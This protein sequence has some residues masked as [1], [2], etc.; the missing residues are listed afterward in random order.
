MKTVTEPT[1]TA[2]IYIAGSMADVERQCAEYC[3][4]VGLCV[5]VEPVKFIYTGGRE[6][7]A[8]VRLVNYPRF[9]TDQDA[10]RAKA[11][12]LAILLIE[13]C[14]QWSAL[15]VDR[16]RTEWLTNRPEDNK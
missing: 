12:T 13:A 11:R 1:F 8:V 3:M 15:I 7:G 2:E 14:S 9:P 4:E 6:A 5:S 16:E 10:I